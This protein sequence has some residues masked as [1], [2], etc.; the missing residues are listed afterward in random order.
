MSPDEARELI[1][2]AY[3]LWARSNNAQ[4]QFDRD[5]QRQAKSHYPRRVLVTG[6]YAM[7][8]PCPA[9]AMGKPRHSHTSP[10]SVTFDFAK[11]SP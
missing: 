5:E 9:M 4:R 7:P 8:V 3:V 1:E 10:G 2:H 11:D 6:G